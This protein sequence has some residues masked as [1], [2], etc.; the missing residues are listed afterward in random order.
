MDI[1]DI[2]RALRKQE[3][4]KLW[5]SFWDEARP[6]ILFATR[7]LPRTT[8]E[9]AHS[10]VK[11]ALIKLVRSW[12]EGK[13]EFS[14]AAYWVI[15][16]AY[17]RTFALDRTVAIPIHA[18]ERYARERNNAGLGA[19]VDVD[20][21]DPMAD[22]VAEVEAPSAH[23]QE[24]E[25]KAELMA[26]IAALPKSLRRACMSK[27]LGDTTTGGV[28]RQANACAFKRAAGI[29]CKNPRLKEIFLALSR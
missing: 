9:D 6:F 15:R 18:C 4:P 19:V 14:S 12:D 20:G 10:E 11:I 26:A 8:E 13:C 17:Q 1:N 2:A 21:K 29:L 7:G 27:L 23:I 16:H 3:T 22:L 25:L 24:E 28:T 5:E